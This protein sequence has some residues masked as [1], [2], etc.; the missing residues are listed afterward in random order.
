[1]ICEEGGEGS[2]RYLM[3][4]VYCINGLRIYIGWR[5]EPYR[6]RG[7]YIKQPYRE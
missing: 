7:F 5:L 6:N 3:K 2:R 4:K 1:M